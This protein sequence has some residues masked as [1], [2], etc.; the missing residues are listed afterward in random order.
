MN[1][2]KKNLLV[3]QSG[4]PTAVFNN[5]LAGVIFE[6][7]KYEEVNGIFGA[8]NGIVGLLNEN[9]IDLRQEDLQTLLGLR[10]APASAIGSCR[11]KLSDNDYEKVLKIIKK[12]NIRYLLINGGNDSMDTAL[13]IN[14]LAKNYN[15][16]I[17]VIG[18]PKTVDNDI[19]YTDHCPGYGSVARW[20]AIATQD[21]G[22]D[23]EAIYTTDSVK[24]L[25]TIGRDTGWVTAATA[26][27]KKEELDAPHLLLIPEVPF[28]KELFLNKVQ[29]IFNEIGYVVITVCE[30]IRDE[31]GKTLFERK[32][33]IDTD[34]FGHPQKGGVGELLVDMISS[35]LGIKAR[36]DKPGTISRSSIMLASKT[37]IEEAFLVGQV[38][39]RY[40][41]KD[42]LTGYM[43][44]LVRG[45][46]EKYICKTNVVELEKVA[47]V[48]KSVP[49]N[50]ITA[51]GYFVT[52]D[53]INYST[54]LIGEPIPEY[55]RLRKIFINF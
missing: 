36:C 51:D 2:S 44:T 15:Y 55:V 49:N 4:G 53:F 35:D 28:K 46:G 31:S 42:N 41:V 9:I 33:D 24:V 19:N 18:I 7:F 52:R 25:E 27:A 6:A 3:I 29:D 11:Y 50:F 12:F 14:N 45:E 10:M 37:D 48:V 40:A 17:N 34:K 5:S 20:Y 30:G 23:I 16:S 8:I 21:V 1:K 32:S 47:N 54:P 38:A 26:L 43:V 39:I 22:K 13:K